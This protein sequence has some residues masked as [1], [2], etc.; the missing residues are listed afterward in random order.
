MTEKIEPPKKEKVAYTYEDLIK[1]SNTDVYS[2]FG[3]V[4]P[5]TKPSAP[6]FSFGTSK[7]DAG[8]KKYVNK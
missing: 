4:K 1:F 8:P 7:R 6:Q 5:S 2:A 3:E